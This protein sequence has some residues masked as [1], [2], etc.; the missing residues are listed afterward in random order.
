MTRLYGRS[1]RGQRVID[2]VPS[3]H[4]NT[5]TLIAAVRADGPRAPMLLAGAMDGDAFLAYVEQV[6]VPT[7]R[8]GDMLVM[9]N[10]STHKNSAAR[11]LIEA[12]GVRILDLPA[13]SPDLNPI[14]KMWSKMKASVRAAAA[15]T[16]EALQDAIARALA[17]VT[18][19]DI[20][21]WFQSCGYNI[22]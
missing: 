6:L 13:Y 1:A 11:R 18:A 20:D 16:Q 15:R 22:K 17:A 3:G 19:S 7:L 2:H 21:G 8:E 10:L 14:E 12:A 9:D 4:W 5:T